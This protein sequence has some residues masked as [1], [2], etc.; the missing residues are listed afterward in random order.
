MTNEKL[1]GSVAAYAKTRNT[2][3]KVELESCWTVGVDE[4]DAKFKGLD[5]RLGHPLLTLERAGVEPGRWLT[6]WE[7]RL[8]YGAACS[9]LDLELG[10]RVDE[11]V[12][13]LGH[14]NVRLVMRWLPATCEED[15]A[16]R[17]SHRHEL[18]LSTAGDFV[19]VGADAAM[20]AI[21][22]FVRDH[23]DNLRK[24]AASGAEV[25]HL[26]VCLDEESSASVTHSVSRRFA[27]PPVAGV[28]H[29]GVPNRSPSLPSEVDELWVV[30]ER[31]GQGWHWDGV[32]WD[33]ID[34]G[35]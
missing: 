17:G 5:G 28:D 9:R 4:R 11:A 33:S 32:G 22:T 7:V 12:V 29:F 30:Y 10:E 8:E 6:P 19:E 1:K 34:A 18:Q 24:L 13:T 2:A 16:R 26:F 3:A 21:E 27:V 23:T 31:E 25:K 14:E 20:Q 15:A 35:R